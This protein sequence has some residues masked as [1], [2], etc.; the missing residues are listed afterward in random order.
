MSQHE[1]S[2]K[3]PACLVQLRKQH[4]PNTPQHGQQL[5]LCTLHAG[6]CMPAVAAAQLKATPQRAAQAER[7]SQLEDSLTEVQQQLQQAEATVSQHEAAAAEAA[8]DAGRQGRRAA[9][10][11]SEAKRLNGELE[12]LS[13]QLQ[14]LEVRHAPARTSITSRCGEHSQMLMPTLGS[15]PHVASQQP[16]LEQETCVCVSHCAQQGC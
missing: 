11:E 15:A 4:E 3:L 6:Q 12:C 10:A 1:L 13:R 14:M 16:E 2:S 9:A 5:P 8:A 7:I